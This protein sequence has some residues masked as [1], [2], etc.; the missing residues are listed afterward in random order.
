[1]LLF[2]HMGLI[3]IRLGRMTHFVKLFA[4]VITDSGK[5][6]EAS[7]ITTDSENGKAV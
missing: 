4:K 6:L 2:W 3:W 1:M 7:A 5:T